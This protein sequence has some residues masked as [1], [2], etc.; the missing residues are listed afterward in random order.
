MIRSVVPKI[1]WQTKVQ[2]GCTECGLSR[3]GLTFVS[4]PPRFL[5]DYCRQEE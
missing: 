5:C 3:T 1:P 4:D 2:R